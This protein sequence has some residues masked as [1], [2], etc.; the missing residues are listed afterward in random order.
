MLRHVELSDYQLWMCKKIKEKLA[1]K[2]NYINCASHFPNE[3][4]EREV[5]SIALSEM[6][7]KLDVIEGKAN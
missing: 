6:L 2:H 1:E 4:E 5:I 3:F 7:M